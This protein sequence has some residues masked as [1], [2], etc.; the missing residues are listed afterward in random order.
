MWA[1]IGFLII[2]GFLLDVS[3]VAGMIFIV[4]VVALWSFSR[5]VTRLERQGG[6]RRV[7]RNSLY[8]RRRQ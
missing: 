3:R 2:A 7:K 4:A 5:Y 8:A 1:F 6:W